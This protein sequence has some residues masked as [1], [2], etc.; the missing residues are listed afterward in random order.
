MFE[1]KGF[2]MKNEGGMGVNSGRVG[3]RRTAPTRPAHIPRR[4]GELVGCWGAGGEVGPASPNSFPC[5]EAL[6]VGG[7]G[8]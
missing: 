8:V 7:A 5:V 6:M 3:N 1:I 2:Q 4:G